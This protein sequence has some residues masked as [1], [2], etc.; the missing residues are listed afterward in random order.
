[1]CEKLKPYPYCGGEAE[2]VKYTD[3]HGLENTGI[4]CTNCTARTI[5]YNKYDTEFAENCKYKQ[6][7]L[8]IIAS[9]AWNNGIIY[10]PRS[11]TLWHYMKGK[12]NN[13]KS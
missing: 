9:V 4:V 13:D 6:Q 10:F 12:L 8:A 1:M 3:K 5:F 7:D 2:L 11:S